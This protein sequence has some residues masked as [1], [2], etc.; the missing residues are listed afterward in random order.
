MTPPD[1]ATPVEK[2]DQS[3]KNSTVAGP[4]NDEATVQIEKADEKCYWNDAAFSQGDRVAVDG[5]CYECSYG[6]WVLVE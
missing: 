6:T 1:D 5:E 3:K 2:M 4:L